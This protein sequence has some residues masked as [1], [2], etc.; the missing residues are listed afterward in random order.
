MKKYLC[1]ICL[2]LFLSSCNHTTIEKPNNLI[3]EEVMTDILYDLSIMDAI[4]SQSPYDAK[5]QSI[6]PKEYIFKKYKI[7]SLQFTESNR[8][9][10]SQIEQYKKMYDKVAE[11]IEKEKATAEASETKKIPASSIPTAEAGQVR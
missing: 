11:R 7:D 10:V 1:I 6:N 2:V 8:Y 9:Y 3:D 5:N 4:K